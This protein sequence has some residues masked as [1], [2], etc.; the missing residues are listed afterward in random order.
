[1]K[2]L[3]KMVNKKSVIDYNTTNCSLKIEMLKIMKCKRQQFLH[4]NWCM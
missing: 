4:N 1:M 2:E 3:V